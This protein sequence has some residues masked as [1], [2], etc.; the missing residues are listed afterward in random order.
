[1]MGMFAFSPSIASYLSGSVGQII[2]PLTG[3]PSIRVYS[4]LFFV[5]AVFA[6]WTILLFFVWGYWDKYSEKLMADA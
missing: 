1:M 3:D 2:T 5:M 4:E 6:L